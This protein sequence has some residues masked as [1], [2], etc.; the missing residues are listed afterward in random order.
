MSDANRLV[1]EPEWR[2]ALAIAAATPAQMLGGRRGQAVT[3]EEPEEPEESRTGQG[4][5]AATRARLRQNRARSSGGSTSVS[6][7]SEAE[8]SRWKALRITNICAHEGGLCRH[9]F[10]PRSEFRYLRDASSMTATSTAPS[11]L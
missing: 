2:P 6:W 9:G 1:R 5:S 4:A 3:S 7:L 10:S 11:A 8:S